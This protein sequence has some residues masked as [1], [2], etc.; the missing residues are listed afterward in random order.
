MQ[1]YVGCIVDV[2]LARPAIQA[3]PPFEPMAIESADI[4][5]IDNGLDTFTLLPGACA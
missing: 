1:T 2:Y 4:H 5:Q 3:A